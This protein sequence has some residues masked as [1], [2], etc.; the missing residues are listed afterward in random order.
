MHVLVT[1]CTGFVGFHTALALQRMGH[2]V[3]FGVRSEAKMRAVYSG[4]DVDLSDF[5]VGCI[6]D[7]AAVARALSGVDA[8]VHCA[9]LVCL[10]AAMAEELIENNV[11]GTKNV[12]GHAVELGIQSIVYVSSISAMFRPGAQLD[13]NSP[14]S[15]TGTVYGRSKMLADQYVRELIAHGAPIAITYPTGII[16][17]DDPGLSD[18]NEGIAFCYKLGFVDTSSGSQF[19]DVRDLAR[20]HV[21]LLERRASGRYVVAGHYLSWRE[22]YA[23][24]QTITGKKL[25]RLPLPG[26]SLRLT[27]R[28]VDLL[29]RVKHFDS[30]LTYEAAIYATQSAIADDSKLRREMDMTLTPLRDTMVDTVAWLAANKHIDSDFL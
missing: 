15:E 19:I 25:R 20:A 9:A 6:T 4:F 3:R 26:W 30:P 8:V 13:E 1:G 28:L 10:D 12:I 11:E 27:G 18:G 29:K 22:I 7:K 23:L 14:Y 21:R 24:H 17:P 16:G 5:A 2:S